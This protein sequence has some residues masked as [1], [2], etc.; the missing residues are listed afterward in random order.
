[1]HQRLDVS[2]TFPFLNVVSETGLTFPTYL[3]HLMGTSVSLP[4][5]YLDVANNSVNESN[6]VLDMDFVC[7]ELQSRSEGD[8]RVQIETEL[9]GYSSSVQRLVDLGPGETRTECLNPVPTNSALQA[10]SSGVR[11]EAAVSVLLAGDLVYSVSESV[12]VTTRNEVFWGMAGEVIGH[13]AVAT[14]VRP[15]ASEV[16]AIFD[17]VVEFSLM[18]SIGTGGYRQG[19]SMLMPTSQTSVS[20]A[21]TA[22]LGLSL[23]IHSLIILNQAESVVIAVSEQGGGEDLDVALVPGLQATDAIAGNWESVD[24]EWYEEYLTPPAATTLTATASGWSPHALVSTN[25]NESSSATATV[26]RSM[27]SFDNAIDY[28]SMI[29]E[30]MRSDGINYINVPSTFF[31]GAQNVLLPD[32]MITNGGGNCID[33]TILFASLLELIGVRPLILILPGHAMVGMWSGASGSSPIVA[34]ETT[35]VG[36]QSVT[37]LEAFQAA[38]NQLA[39]APWILAIDL[40]SARESGLLPMP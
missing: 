22:M 23:G 10:L 35:M 15:H 11:S 7:V 26:A 14:L 18:G 6:S 5:A 4:I 2:H 20:A 25:Y 3:A 33:G 13:A 17:D 8:L 32:E 40:V 38:E 16:E 30:A 36:S 31:E 27:T 39:A 37:A 19:T 12:A 1:M 28:L 24:T 21:Q 34:I 29:F 9:V